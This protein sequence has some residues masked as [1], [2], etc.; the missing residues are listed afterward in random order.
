[1]IKNFIVSV[2]ESEVEYQ[3]GGEVI[4]FEELLKNHEL[5]HRLDRS[6]LPVLRQQVCEQLASFERAEVLMSGFA[7]LLLK[8]KR[9]RIFPRH[10]RLLGLISSIDKLLKK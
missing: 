3:S 10:A 7:R 6:E 5:L 2:E 4:R 9:T 1:M 8:N